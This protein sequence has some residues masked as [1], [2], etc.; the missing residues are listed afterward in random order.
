[1]PKERK[2]NS[3]KKEWANWAELNPDM[4]RI[5]SRKLCDIRSFISFRVVCKRWR[6]TTDLSNCPRQFP[7]LIDSRHYPDTTLRVYSPTSRRTHIFEIPRTLWY[8]P[9]GGDVLIQSSSG[10]GLFYLNPLVGVKAAFPD[11]VLSRNFVSTQINSRIDE[12]VV[13]TEQCY[14]VLYFKIS[15]TDGWTKKEFCYLKASAYHDLKLFLL[16]VTNSVPP[17]FNPYRVTV[18]N[19]INGAELPSIPFLKP[20]YYPLMYLIATTDSLLAII[21]IIPS[22]FEDLKKSQFEVHQLENYP[23]NPH[24]TKLIGIGDLMLFLNHFN[25]FSLRATKYSGFKGNCIYF[26]ARCSKPLGG[27]KHV[28]GRWDMGLNQIEEHSGPTWFDSLE[29]NTAW[30]KKCGRER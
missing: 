1:M 3:R 13:V 2:A 4:L 10:M 5:I 20:L 24:C 25:G 14:D 7:C 18:I 23:Q 16:E 11:G 6:S 30:C 17:I 12:F 19:K 22:R 8:E 28:I 26:T 21:G 9:S 27:M 29:M 15:D